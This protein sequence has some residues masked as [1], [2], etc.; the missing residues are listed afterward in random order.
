MKKIQS[1]QKDINK[2]QKALS[3][4]EQTENYILFQKGILISEICKNIRILEDKQKTLLE[5]VSK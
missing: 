5:I 4:I 2:L 1:I 3:L